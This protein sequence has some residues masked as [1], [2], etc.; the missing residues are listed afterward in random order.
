MCSHIHKPLL[1]QNRR[2][3]DSR[4]PGLS[5]RLAVLC[6]RRVYL[7]LLS[8]IR[9][10]LVR[11]HRRQRAGVSM[12]RS[13]GN[14]TLIVACSGQRT[15]C[16]Q[17]RSISARCVGET[18]R[19]RYGT[20]RASHGEHAVLA[21]NLALTHAAATTGRYRSIWDRYCNG[22]DAI[23]C[24]LVLHARP[25]TPFIPPHPQLRCRLQRRA[26]PLSPA[27]RSCGHSYPRVPQHEKFEVAKFELHQLLTFPNL[28]SVP[29][30]VV[31]APL[32]PLSLIF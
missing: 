1:L 26:F 28:K 16:P 14:R 3:N 10:D 30:L 11:E 9:Q 7:R 32:P 12:L 24:V 17:S 29:L 19:S 4:P 25:D 8:G 31:R 5:S 15:S 2:N 22:V 18:S 6:A 13:H 21:D 27:P 20:S 23:V